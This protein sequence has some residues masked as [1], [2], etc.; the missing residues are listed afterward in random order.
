MIKPNLDEALRPMEFH[1][2]LK[3]NFPFNAPRLA[4]RSHFTY[5][6]LA[7]GRDFLRD[8]LNKEWSASITLCD[9]VNALPEFI[10]MYLE[11]YNNT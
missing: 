9:I 4:V 8:V 1:I 3:N 2:Y 7:D 10:V 5:P 11:C 6:S